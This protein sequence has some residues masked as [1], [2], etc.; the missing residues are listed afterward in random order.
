MQIALGEQAA[1]C[2]P[3]D[4]ASTPVAGETGDEQARFDNP[5]SRTAKSTIDGRIAASLGI[6]FAPD[7]T[8]RES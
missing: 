8:T 6:R 4:E 3:F 5:A 1:P 2:C 7:S